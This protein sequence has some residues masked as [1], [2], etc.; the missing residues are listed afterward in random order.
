MKYY[1]SIENS[2]P[3]PFALSAIK[4]ERRLYLTLTVTQTLQQSQ[5]QTEFGLYG[6][7]YFEKGVEHT[8]RKSELTSYCQRQQTAQTH[9]KEESGT[10][11]YMR[12]LCYCEHKPEIKAE[13]E[14]ST[15]W[16]LGE[17]QSVGAQHT[18]LSV[19]KSKWS[20]ELL[21]W[22]YAFHHWWSLYTMP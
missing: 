7:S 2:E 18:L 17:E 13:T 12:H 22:V 11:S 15:S 4:G 3:S 5:S 1:L 8:F 16:T 10:I 19:K 20:H 21:I 14:I 9:N 6:Q